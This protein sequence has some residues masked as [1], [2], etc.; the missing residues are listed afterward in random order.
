MTVIIKIEIY[1]PAKGG[2][3]LLMQRPL[4]L[5]MMTTKMNCNN[6]IYLTEEKRK[7]IEEK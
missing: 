4:T 7:A 2:M 5:A 3:Y 6:K 1:L